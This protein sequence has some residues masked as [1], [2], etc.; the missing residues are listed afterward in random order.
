MG[1]GCWG[2]QCCHLQRRLALI[3]QRHPFNRRYRLRARFVWLFWP[4]R[5]RLAN[6]HSRSPGSFFAIRSSPLLLAVATGT[7]SCLPRGKMRRKQW[8]KVDLDRG[9]G[10]GRDECCCTKP[11]REPV[12]GGNKGDKQLHLR[13]RRLL[14]SFP[15]LQSGHRQYMCVGGYAGARLGASLVWCCANRGVVAWRCTGASG[16]T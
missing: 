5:R 13:Q 15:S 9:G 1:Q 14:G 10:G 16:A 7:P 3:S 4:S 11:R 6:F 12:P 2:S 8:V